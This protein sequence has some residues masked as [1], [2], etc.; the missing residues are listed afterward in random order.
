MTVPV[1][2]L[3]LLTCLNKY[4]DLHTVLRLVVEQ[5]IMRL[6]ASSTA[7]HTTA[8]PNACP[9]LCSQMLG[10]A[11]TAKKQTAINHNFP[12]NNQTIGAVFCMVNLTLAMSSGKKGCSCAHDLSAW[13]SLN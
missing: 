7:Q 6:Y 3:F 5:I 9:L 1:G 8:K 2:H 4:S 10:R 13:A 11:N 12:Q